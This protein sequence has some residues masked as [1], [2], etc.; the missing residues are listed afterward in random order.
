M[1]KRMGRLALGSLALALA[2]VPAPSAAQLTTGS[3]LIRCVDDQGAVMP[4]A[5]ITISSGVLVAG[6]AVGVT[7]TGGSH[8]FPSLPPGEY[9]IRVELTGFQTIVRE[10][11]RVLV[12]ETTPLE[13]KM[14]LASLAET[15][16]VRGDSPTVDTTSANVN[17]HLDAKLLETTPSGRD[18]WSIVEYKVPGVVMGSPDVGGNQG[19]LQRSLESRGTANSQNTQMLNGVNVGDPAAIG[20]AGYYY[21]PSSFADIQVSSGAQDITVPSS[22]VF[23][24]MVTKGGSN[25][26]EGTAL[27][28]YQ[29]DGTQWDNIDEDLQF[30]GIRPN[31]NAVDRITN[32]N[33]S[34]GGPILR[35]R[36]F[37]FAALNDQR[38]H[39]NVVG[40][41]AVP[42]FGPTTENTDITSIFANSTY[43]LSTA[44][45]LQG[46]VSRQV[47]D[48]PNR[49]ASAT[50][51]PE[52]TWHEHDV[53]AVYQGL[54]NWVISNNL[55]ADSRASFNS[56]DFPLQL[57]TTEQSLLDQST[58]IRTRANTAH[59]DMYRR[60]LQVSTNLQYYVPELLGGRHEFRFGIDNAY[61]PEDVDIL[62]NDDVNL[63]YR[64]RPSGS[65]PAGPTDVTLFN[66]PLHLKRAVMATALYAQDSYSYKRL[67]VVGGVRWE[68]IEGW[69]PAQSNPPSRWFPEGTIIP[70]TIGGQPFDFEVQRTFDEVRDIPLWKNAGPRVSAV[71]DLF[72]TGKTALKASAAR[73]YATIGTGTP[74]GLSP[75]GTIS[76]RFAWNDVNGDLIFQAGEQGRLLQTN[77][78]DT[79]ETLNLTRDPDL[80]R[81][82]QNEFTVG[83]DHELIRN[84]RLS[85]TWIYRKEKDQIT[86]V[87][88]NVPFEAYTPLQVN[89]PGRDGEFGTVD[90]GVLTVYNENEPLQAHIEQDRNDDRVSES[91]KG[92]ELTV[93][94]RF[95]DNW[96]LLAGYT[97]GR[98]EADLLGVADPNEA[99]VNAA[100]RTGGREH[101]FKLTGSYL[102]PYGIQLGGNFRL[103]SGRF[104]TRVV[105]ISG[106]NQGDIDVF[107]EPRGSVTLDRLPTLDLRIGKIF[108]FGAQEF[109]AD[110]DFYNV[111]NENTV[112]NVRTDTGVIN[113]RQAGDPNGTVNTVPEFL[114]PTGILGPRI[115]RFNIRYRFG[116]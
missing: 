8:R 4:G 116:G 20:F 85:A 23:I 48:K 83:V 53:L 94:K 106:L 33:L 109:E 96:T 114:S 73:Y 98:Q 59:Q 66:S 97:W 75:N 30:V 91:F 81:P 108:R 74:G 65:T 104:I 51:T 93:H 71:Y 32:L 35:N 49:G 43:Q 113:V 39:V 101:I 105:E 63:R 15:V 82:Y 19:G 61:T 58:N 76:Q 64:T 18:I 79:Q 44:H 11:I 2:L 31:A 42:T 21:D 7:G 56:I 68:R 86:D 102:L 107:A 3:I 69:I 80:R 46:T 111:T 62:R 14:T 87:V 115:V 27:Y 29:G 40:F 41:P 100:G 5:T 103:E 70:T 95:S 1:F 9:T 37:Y 72:G 77:V 84:V 12:G 99:L 57:K 89:E 45:R 6:Q 26:F 54:W 47:Y 38:T 112:F 16:T 52:S 25:R 88:L 90:D 24:N 10:N 60:R 17:V 13:L 50:N 22:G 34:A 92:I 78:P 36:L 28:T 55:F 67:T 110:V